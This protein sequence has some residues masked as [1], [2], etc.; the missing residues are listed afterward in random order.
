MWSYFPSNVHAPGWVSDL[1]GV[2]AEAAPAISTQEVTRG[3]NSDGVL[4]ALAPNMVDL[5][6]VVESGKTAAQKI[7]RPVLFGENGYSTVAYEVDAV[8]DELGIV[9]EVEAGRA[10]RGNAAYRDLIRTSLIL[11]AKFLVLMLPIVYRYQSSGKT[12]T[13]MVYRDTLEQ[14]KAIYASRRLTLPFEGV[15]LVGY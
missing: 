13:V 6:Y 15:L 9:V 11:D 4:A 2:V 3:L 14:L 10:A 1:T 7:R 5:G 8:H 12:A